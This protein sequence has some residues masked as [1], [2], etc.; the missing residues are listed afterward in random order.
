MQKKTNFFLLAVLFFLLGGCSPSEENI[1]P[2]PPAGLLGNPVQIAL[3]RQLFAAHCAECHGSLAEGRTQVAARLTPVPPDFHE[4]RYRRVLP[5]YLFRRI[6]QGRRLEPFRSSGSVMPAWQQ[7]LNQDQ[8]W[9]L[10]A[11]LRYRAGET[12]LMEG[13]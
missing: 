5:G 9:S 11:F 6:A 7:H 13:G 8:I 10:V 2:V 4:R 12:P 3:G 1:L